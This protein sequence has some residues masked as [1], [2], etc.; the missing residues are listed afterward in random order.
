MQGLGMLGGVYFVATSQGW[1]AKALGGEGG[2]V[3]AAR[4]LVGL[5]WLVSGVLLV[6]AAWA[7]FKDLEW[8]RTWAVYGAPLSAAAIVL[9]AGGTLPPGAYAGALFDVLILGYALMGR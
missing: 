6:G 4:V 8:W 7:F 3:T 1:L 9:W 2:V 5:M